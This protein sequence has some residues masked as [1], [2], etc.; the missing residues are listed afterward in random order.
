MRLLLFGKLLHRS[1]K[2]ERIALDTEFSNFRGNLLSFGLVPEDQSIPP[3]YVVIDYEGYYDPWVVKNV[4]PFLGDQEKVS[5]EFAARQFA[6]YLRQFDNP[7]LIADWPEDI[8]QM[9]SLLI[10]GPGKMVN[11][12]NFTC[13][14]V[15]TDFSTADHSAIPHNALED[16]RALAKFLFEWD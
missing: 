12:P 10:I 2:L 1:I 13:S 11:C 8:N 3:L 15:R 4:I 7:V 5:P 9:M 6:Q 16:A 14:L